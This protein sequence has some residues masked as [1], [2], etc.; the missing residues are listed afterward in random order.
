MLCV[1]LISKGLQKSFTKSFRNFEKLR[2]Q[3]LCMNQM[4]RKMCQPNDKN[5]QRMG[6]KKQLKKFI[7]R[8]LSSSTSCFAQT[9]ISGLLKCKHRPCGF[10]TMKPMRSC[11]KTAP[12][13]QGFIRFSVISFFCFYHFRANLI[14]LEYS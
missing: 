14:K 5:P 1:A 6:K 3:K 13:Y 2:A 8:K 11:I 4:K 10:L 9:L 12:T 7:R